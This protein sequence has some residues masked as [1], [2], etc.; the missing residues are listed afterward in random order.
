MFKQTK[1][2]TSIRNKLVAAVAML[3]VASIMMVSSSYAWFTLST[4]PEVTGITT[5]VGSNGNLE[6]ALSPSDGSEPKTTLGD[7]VKDIIE[8]NITWGNL[9]DLSSSA[10]GLDKLIMNLA[11]YDNTVNSLNTN[12]LSFPTYGADGRPSSLVSDSTIGKFNAASGNFEGVTIEPFGVRGVGS[13]STLSK[14]QAGLNNS[15]AA[16]STNRNN[17]LTTMRKALNDNGA[18]LADMMIAKETANQTEFVTWVDDVGALLNGIKTSL[19]Y[20][21]AGLYSVIEAYVASDV[22]GLSDEAEY[23]AALALVRGKGLDFWMSAD[24]TDP[25][26]DAELH[27][28]VNSA[29]NG[30]ENFKNAYDKY[31]AM[32]T[33]IATADASY[34]TISEKDM[35]SWTDINSVLGLLVESEKIYIC[36]YPASQVKDNMGALMAAVTGGGGLQ[37]TL[38]AGSGLFAD[39]AMLVGDYSAEIT[40][41]AISVPGVGELPAGM[42]AIMS[43]TCISSDPKEGQIVSPYMVVLYGSLS[44]LQPSNTSAS[45]VVLNQMYGYIIDLYFRT[46][47]AESNL[48]L[49]TEAADRVYEENNGNNSTTQGGGA[50]M[51]FKVPT[52]TTQAQIEALVSAIRVL[53]FSPVDGTVIA[54]ARLDPTTIESITDANG[55]PARI[56]EMKIWIPE[57][58]VANPE[59]V[60]GGDQP[61]T[62][63]EPAHFATTDEE[64]IIMPLVQNQ[65][66]RLSVMVYIDGHS[67]G[68]EDVANAA[69]SMVGLLNLQF[70]SDADL[71]PMNYAPLKDQAGADAPTP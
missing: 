69:Q 34:A 8:R 67:I 29:L 71:Q 13:S 1:A 10:Y 49:Q 44:N 68:N 2:Y 5:T 48:L 57:K 38:E 33:T 51:T 45:T 37:V 14:Q 22:A 66:T 4:A 24:A 70:A 56:A 16:V 60:E 61:E 12:P 30:N 41:G 58:T 43:T 64:R 54:E 25:A 27:T 63:Q 53:F 17:A 32:K 20:V 7:S 39:M 15:V 50:N 36:G 46:N 62:I 40:L 19:T 23:T 55:D 52:I 28:A 47:A 21:E 65:A 31:A 3:L 26:V 6:I 35:V 9:V 59:Y 11:A 42:K 18:A